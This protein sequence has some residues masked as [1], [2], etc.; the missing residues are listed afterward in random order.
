M[1]PGGPVE[2]VVGVD[3]GVVDLKGQ[4]GP[5]EDPQ[6]VVLTTLQGQRSQVKVKVKGHRS[7]SRVIAVYMYRHGSCLEP[8]F[9]LNSEPYANTALTEIFISTSNCLFTEIGYLRSMLVKSYLR[10]DYG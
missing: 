4:V 5:A 7:R 6:H 2:A 1:Q 9:V 3:L 8:R 10:L